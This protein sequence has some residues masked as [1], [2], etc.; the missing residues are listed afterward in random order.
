MDFGS[1]SVY[2]RLM[3]SQTLPQVSLSE[4]AA[5]RLQ[6]M[7]NRML[8]LAVLGGGCSGFQYKFDYA[9]EPE[10]EDRVFERDGAKLVVDTVSLD[11][12]AGSEVNF[13]ENLMGSYFEVKNP[14]AVSSCG[15]GTSFSI[16]E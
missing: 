15:C 7:G 14:N 5:R 2:I 1:I 4:S 6:A 11:L 12:V 10:T 8:R 3:D 16:G 9:D 13:V